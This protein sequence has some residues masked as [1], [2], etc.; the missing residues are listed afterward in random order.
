M[1]IDASQKLPCFLP[2]WP[3]F[4]TRSEKKDDDD[5]DSILAQADKT[6]AQSLPR[7]SSLTSSFIDFIEGFTD[8]REWRRDSRRT[9][10]S[11]VTSVPDTVVSGSINLSNSLSGCS[12]RRGNLYGR[13][14]RLREG[15]GRERSCLLNSLFLS[16]SLY[17]ASLRF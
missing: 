15:P 5:H 16:L 6:T 4:V 11:A 17:A 10:R 3:F 7:S 12:C 8:R 1:S 14:A 9:G 13:Q 2:S